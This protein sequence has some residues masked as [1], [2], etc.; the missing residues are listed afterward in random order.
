ME[1]IESTSGQH[2][3][4][5]PQ[6]KKM[7]KKS[8]NRNLYVLSNE[9]PIRGKL[10]PWPDAKAL[11][12]FLFFFQRNLYAPV[13]P[14]GV[15]LSHAPYQTDSKP[16]TASG[17]G[18]KG[19]TV[20]CAETPKTVCSYLQGQLIKHIRGHGGHSRPIVS[21]GVLWFHAVSSICFVVTNSLL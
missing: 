15:Q 18:G 6:E 4:F 5:H 7:T 9:C 20:K 3:H 2:G 10:L 16:V 19:Q 17:E 13:S 1:T 12:V 21:W 8:K 14:D 11:V